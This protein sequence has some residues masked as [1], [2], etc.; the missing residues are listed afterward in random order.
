MKKLH[1]EIVRINIFL[2]FA[3]FEEKFDICLLVF[4]VNWTAFL[5]AKL[6]RQMVKKCP[7]FKFCQFLCHEQGSNNHIRNFEH[8][9]CKLLATL[10][11]KLL[12]IS[13]LDLPIRSFSATCKQMSNFSPNFAS[14]KK[15]WC[16]QFPDAVFSWKCSKGCIFYSHEV[17]NLN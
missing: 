3:K 12:E 11:K 8:Y 6:D 7:L 2:E 14:S 16:G 4:R 17:W 10:V 5:R 9:F 13:E 1:L 15:W